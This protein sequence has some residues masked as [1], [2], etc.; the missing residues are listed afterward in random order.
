L[1]IEQV[2]S[3]FVSIRFRK[4]VSGLEVRLI[5]VI[6]RE[7]VLKTYVNEDR[8]NY[9]HFLIQIVGKETFLDYSTNEIIE[10]M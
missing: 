10:E 6:S 8:K 5:S 9:D 4:Y 7:S 3:Y 1:L 2:S